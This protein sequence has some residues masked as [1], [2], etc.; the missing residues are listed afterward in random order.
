MILS[1]R[2]APLNDNPSRSRT[3]HAFVLLKF[4]TPSPHGTRQS[5][6]GPVKCEGGLELATLFAL[7][8]APSPSDCHESHRQPS[9]HRNPTLWA[10][11]ARFL[12]PRSFCLARSPI[13][14]PKKEPCPAVK[15]LRSGFGENHTILKLP[16][17]LSLLVPKLFAFAYPHLL[18]VLLVI[19]QRERWETPLY[20]QSIF[21]AR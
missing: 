4:N 6:D 15:A 14:N 20:P 19:A 18:R 2:P 17:T 3:V 10:R 21:P 13:G 7:L 11:L 5:L 12:T 16:F 8:P 9:G 1:V